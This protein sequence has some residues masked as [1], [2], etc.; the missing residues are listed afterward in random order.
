MKLLVYVLILDLIWRF[1]INFK[2]II[3]FLEVSY[4]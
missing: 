1:R 4:V 3:E 2:E